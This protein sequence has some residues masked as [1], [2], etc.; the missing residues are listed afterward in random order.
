MLASWGLKAHSK[1]LPVV[2]PSS[3]PGCVGAGGL[4]L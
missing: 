1:V 3:G 2:I 4:E